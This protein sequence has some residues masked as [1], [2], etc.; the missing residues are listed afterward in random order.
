[1]FGYAASLF[2]FAWLSDRFG[3][4]RLF[5]VSAVLSASPRAEETGVA[6]TD[7]ARAEAKQIYDT[8][9]TPCHGATGKGD[10]VA[11]AALTPKPK[12]LSDKAWQD[13]V[14]DDY[15]EKIILKGGPAVEKSPLMPPNPDLDAKPAVVVALREHVR[16]L[17]KPPAPEGRVRF[18]LAEGAAARAA[19]AEDADV[20]G[21]GMLW[22][23]CVLVLAGHGLGA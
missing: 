1:M 10:G 17:A 18:V 11:A 19:L 6:V 8:R 14:K 20:G 21:E 4:K 23:R 3:A 5:L 2:V 16:A 9:C 13:S 7:E 22:G 12:D 15:I